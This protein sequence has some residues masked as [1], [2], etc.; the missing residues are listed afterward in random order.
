MFRR[1]FLF[2][3]LSAVLALV[4]LAG[5]TMHGGGRV[6]F[7]DVSTGL[8]NGIPTEAT[9]AVSVN[10]NENK[11][12]FRSNINLVDN[13][14]GAHINAHLEWTPVSTFGGPATC[15]EAK[16]FVEQQGASLAFGI[17]SSHGQ[18]NG[19]AAVV[20]GQ[21]GADLTNCGALQPIV[22]QATENT[23]DSLPGGAYFAA[24]CL[25]HG[26]ISFK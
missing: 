23:P 5:C 4:V 20:V 21:A 13:T 10:C 6:A 8:G 25:D 12:L 11:N 24:G 1:S 14:N 3:W 16:A 2:F 7:F 22:V 26:K 15:A 17:I 18:E 19:Q 9:I